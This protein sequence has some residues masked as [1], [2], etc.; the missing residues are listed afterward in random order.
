LVQVST[1]V[2]NAAKPSKASA[3]VNDKKGRDRTF[4]ACA[5]LMAEYPKA[6]IQL[7]AQTPDPDAIPGRAH[8]NATV[9]YG[10]LTDLNFCRLPLVGHPPE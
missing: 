7:D 10:L 2:S 9:D 3:G 1:N 8:S 6:D 5:D 4:V